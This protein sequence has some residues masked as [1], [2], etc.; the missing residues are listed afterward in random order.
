MTRSKSTSNGDHVNK[1]QAIRE[2]LLQHPDLKPKEIAALLAQ[3]KI[4]VKPSM[5][6][7]VKGILAQMKH[8]RE[9]KAERASVASQKT[10]SSDPI[11]LILKVKELARDAGGMTNLQR[12]VTVLAD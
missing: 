11:A 9:R 1:S 8:Q 3:R 5:I 12:L 2:M 4:A 7:M 6:Y 10:G